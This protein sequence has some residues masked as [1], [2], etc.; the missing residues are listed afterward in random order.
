MFELS[1]KYVD[2]DKDEEDE[3]LLDKITDKRTRCLYLCHGVSS[4]AESIRCKILQVQ[5]IELLESLKLSLRNISQ[6]YRNF[7]DQ[8]S[9]TRVVNYVETMT[10]VNPNFITLRQ[11]EVHSLCCEIQIFCK[12]VTPY[13]KNTM[14]DRAIGQFFNIMSAT[15]KFLEKTVMD[16]PI[17]HAVDPNPPRRKK[18]FKYY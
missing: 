14:I 11:I 17:F 8:Y 3:L 1:R 15:C 7:S 5:E 4:S 9:K 10:W 12:H 6:M 13:M 18:C 2:T 16:N